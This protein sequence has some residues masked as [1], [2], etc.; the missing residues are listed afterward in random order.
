MTRRALVPLTFLLLASAC[1]QAPEEG[2]TAE[3]MSTESADAMAP[4]ANTEA[5]KTSAVQIAYTY[6]YRF[7]LP[8]DV[9]TSTQERHVDLCESLGPSRCRIADL[10]RSAS[11][12]DYSGGSLKLMV[13]A[14][15][16]RSFGQQL[17][18]AATEA[19]G[20]TVDRAIDAEDLARQIVDVD[21]RI[22]TKEALVARLTK[23]LETR[24]GNIAQA[25]E[26]ERAINAAQ[27]ELEQAR[28]QIAVMRGR[29]AMSTFEI[30][31]ESA[32]PLAGG[33][34]EPLRESFASVGSLFGR[35][36]GAIVYF[37]AVLLP[38]LMAGGAIAFAVRFAR[39]RFFQRSHEAFAISGAA[40]AE[41]AD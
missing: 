41:A 10:K 40:A 6:S 13:A 35:S 26:A 29:V 34:T 16:A 12:G 25:V 27:E 4:G 11:S 5:V 8:S 23:L 15:F 17:V 22:R 2:G 28:A 7:R 1:G 33:F 14:P 3:T 32:A 37:L 21:A 36:L 9:V 30:G 39:Q 24:S 20:E 19:G 31:Y 38:W 18:S